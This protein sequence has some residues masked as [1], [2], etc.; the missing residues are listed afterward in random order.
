MYADLLSDAQN[1]IKHILNFEL[2]EL[3]DFLHLF[4]R[5]MTLKS[6]HILHL[7]LLYKVQ[8]TCRKRAGPTNCRIHL[9]EI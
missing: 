9:C 7:Y 2:K 5:T 1:L 8:L 3:Y 4:L 6:K